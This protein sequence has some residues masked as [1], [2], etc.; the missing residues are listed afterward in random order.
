MLFEVM[1]LMKRIR[2]PPI[3][4]QICHPEKC[5]VIPTKG[6]EINNNNKTKRK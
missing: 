4:H 6:K 2:I 5:L 1:I 3:D